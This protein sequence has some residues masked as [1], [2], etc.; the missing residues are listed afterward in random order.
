MNLVIQP[1]YKTVGTHKGCLF[2]LKWKYLIKCND[3]CSELRSISNTT[4]KHCRIRQKKIMLIE[5]FLGTNYCTEKRGMRLSYL[6]YI[7]SSILK[8]ECTFCSLFL[9]INY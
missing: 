5:V 1:Q 9:F 4:E 3:L 2:L 6:I 7:L 8:E